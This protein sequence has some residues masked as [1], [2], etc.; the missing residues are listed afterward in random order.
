MKSSNTNNCVLNIDCKCKKCSPDTL[1]ERNDKK[2]SK[3]AKLVFDMKL[4]TAKEIFDSYVS[5]IKEAA[6][7]EG[8]AT[9]MSDMASNF[10]GE[11]RS[12]AFEEGKKAMKEEILKL[13]PKEDKKHFIE[14][15]DQ[16]FARGFNKCRS[17]VLSAIEK[18]L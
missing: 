5:S 13:I 9:K 8:L 12:K 1:I 16:L 4:E 6:Y 7:E 14:F 11:I 18:I 17:I 2:F 15:Q 3:I 10:T